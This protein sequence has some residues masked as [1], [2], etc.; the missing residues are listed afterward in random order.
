MKYKSDGLVLE[1][2]GI[3]DE[4]TFPWEWFFCKKMWFSAKNSIISILNAI[5]NL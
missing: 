5:K 2:E 3:E 1:D 4:D